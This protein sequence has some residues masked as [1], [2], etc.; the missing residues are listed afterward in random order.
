MC[1]TDKICYFH[2]PSFTI[3]VKNG[4]VE[5]LIGEN[6]STE[7]KVVLTVM[8]NIPIDYLTEPNTDSD[9]STGKI[10]FTKLL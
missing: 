5:A 6:I 8:S 3:C 2:F 1:V 4:P 7:A 9:L 10:L